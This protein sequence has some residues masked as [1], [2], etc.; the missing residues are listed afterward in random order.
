M[1]PQ[2]ITMEIGIV[3]GLCTDKRVEMGVTWLWA[4]VGLNGVGLWMDSIQK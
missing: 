4:L 3:I 1:A 2:A